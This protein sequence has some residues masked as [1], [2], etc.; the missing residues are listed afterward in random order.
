LLLVLFSMRMPIKRQFYTLA[1]TVF[2]L[3][4]L[5]F[6]TISC[7]ATDSIAEKQS[8]PDKIAQPANIVACPA[9]SSRN[10]QAWVDEAAVNEPR[11]NISGEVDLPTPNYKAKWKL[12]N[13]DRYS[14]LARNISISFTPPKGMVIQVVTPTK[15]SFSLPF[16]APDRKIVKIYCG[17]KLLAEM[18]IV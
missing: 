17:D 14:S 18:P 2:I 16:S 7:N 1:C 4:A 10:W 8:T 12:E 11:L 13:S 6:I 15:V 3:I 5:A 9:L